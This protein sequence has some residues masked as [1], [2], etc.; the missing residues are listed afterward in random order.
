MQKGKQTR[1]RMIKKCSCD[2]GSSFSGMGVRLNDEKKI[3]RPSVP[4]G[5]A[6]KIRGV[7]GGFSHVL[8]N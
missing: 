1:K 8:A 4:E 5:K 3:G 7:F 6:C 2:D